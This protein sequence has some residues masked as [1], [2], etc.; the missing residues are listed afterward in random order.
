M[1][2][3]IRTYVVQSLTRIFLSFMYTA[4]NETLN[5]EVRRLKLLVGEIRGSSTSNSSYQE[6]RPQMMQPEQLK[7]HNQH[8]TL[9]VGDTRGSIVSNSSYQERSPQT[10]KPV[11]LKIHNHQ[12]ARLQ[13]DQELQELEKFLTQ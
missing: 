5:D 10:M 6:T 2:V 1:D 11:D 12:L 13:Q 3:N 9:V 4:L 7:I 8:P